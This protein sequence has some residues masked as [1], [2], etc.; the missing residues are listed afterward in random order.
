M[1]LLLWADSAVAKIGGRSFHP[2]YL[3]V[4]G[5]PPAAAKN[6]CYLIGFI[7]KEANPILA[8]DAICA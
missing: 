3:V 4:L 1:M 2:L 8:Y 5:L 7:T 6:A